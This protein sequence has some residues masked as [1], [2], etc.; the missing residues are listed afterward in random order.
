MPVNTLKQASILLSKAQAVAIGEIAASQA[1]ILLSKAQAVAIGEIAASLPSSIP[2]LTVEE[3]N[4]PNA[5]AVIT[6]RGSTLVGHN[7]QVTNVGR[8][9]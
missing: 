4:V 7:G 6:G 3:T 8:G 5:V 1:S 2:A 9:A